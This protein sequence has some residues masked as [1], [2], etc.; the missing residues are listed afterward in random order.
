MRPTSYD[1]LYAPNAEIRKH[2]GLLQTGLS[3]VLP[4]VGGKYWI[5]EEWMNGLIGNLRCS[6]FP[7][8]EAV[9]ERGA[10]TPIVPLFSTQSRAPKCWISLHQSW[11]EPVS[12][13]SKSLTYHTTSI[14]VF[15][16]AV[17]KEKI[18]LFRA[19]W[20]GLRKLH[21]DSV[22]FESPGAGH[23]HWQFDAYQQH[24]RERQEEEQR[25][26][27][28]E[29]LNEEQPEAKEFTDEVFKGESLD[30]DSEL[31]AHMQRLTKIHF[32][33]STRWANNPLDS[34]VSNVEAHAHAPSS[35][36][37]ILNW[38]TSVIAYIQQEIS[39]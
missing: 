18:Q 6:S 20:P 35:V 3:K 17:Q 9:R 22:E 5:Q 26:A 19:E 27:I 32:A 23:P 11:S 13:R 8:V 30:H 36:N 39:R 24:L 4:R 33:S 16:G 1:V 28:W 25:R 21:D 12:G 34:E 7:H 37:E 38:S 31:P 10:D 14:T 2:W 15:C 29:E